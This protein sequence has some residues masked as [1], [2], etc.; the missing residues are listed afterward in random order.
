MYII[1][2]IVRVCYSECPDSCNFYHD[3][4]NKTPDTISDDFIRRMGYYEVDFYDMKEF[5]FGIIKND[6]PLLWTFFI[7]KGFRCKDTHI[8]LFNELRKIA[9]Q[10][11]L[12]G[13]E[14]R[15]IP[16]YKFLKKYSKQYIPEIDG[17]LLDLEDLC[18]GWS[19]QQ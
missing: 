12:S 7:K 16:A 17:F 19:Q 2:N 14:E 5:Y 1:K 18:R 13:C 9:G 4:A 6:I 11:I 10:Y 3:I 8:K 15:N